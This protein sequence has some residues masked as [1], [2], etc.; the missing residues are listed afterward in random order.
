MSF[1][2]VSN[3]QRQIQRAPSVVYGPEA[4]PETN[5]VKTVLYHSRGLR[6][7]GHTKNNDKPS[8]GQQIRLGLLKPHELLPQGL[9][10][11]HE[12]PNAKIRIKNMLFYALSLICFY[13]C[14]S[15]FEMLPLNKINS[16]LL[17]ISLFGSGLLIYSWGHYQRFGVFA[18]SGTLKD[19]II[20]YP[21]KFAVE[22]IQIAVLA[23]FSYLSIKKD[24]FY[25][26]LAFLIMM[27]LSIGELPTRSKGKLTKNLCLNL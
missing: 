25:N 3:Q 12:P 10:Q 4:T 17:A 6:F 11:I 2:R 14:I 1:S 5:L 19:V 18:R 13:A 22:F 20:R 15:F 21:K 24:T 16:I 7:R 27:N 26:P 8:I 9:T 23:I